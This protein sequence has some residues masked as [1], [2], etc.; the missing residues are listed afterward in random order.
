MLGTTAKLSN[1]A[2]SSSRVVVTLERNLRLRSNCNSKK[3]TETRNKNIKR[4]HAKKVCKQGKG[5]SIKVKVNIKAMLHPY[6]LLHTACSQTACL[7]TK[8]APIFGINNAV[9][10]HQALEF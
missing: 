2:V 6:T 1:Y 7:K 10:E 5:D 4:M 8:P 9:N 3:K